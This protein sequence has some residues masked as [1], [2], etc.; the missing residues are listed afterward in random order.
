MKAK[1]LR[2]QSD[3]QL[4]DILRDSAKEMFNLRFRSATEKINAP[5]KLRELRRRIAR[6]KTIQRLREIA[7]AKTAE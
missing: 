3:D 7:L 1:E 2:E 6:I 4:V 5:S